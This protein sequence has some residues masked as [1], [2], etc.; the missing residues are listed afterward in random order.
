MNALR[1]WLFAPGNHD[2]KIEKVFKVAADVVVL[3]LEDSVPRASKISC[4]SKV[5]KALTNELNSPC[6]KYIRVNSMDTEFCYADI[7]EAIGPW[8]DGLLLPK[9]EHEHQLYTIDWLISQIERDRDMRVGGLDVVPIIET[10]IGLSN[11][12][13]IASTKTR[14][15]RLSFGAGDFTNDM[16][17][18]WTAEENEL[19]YA[20]SKISLAS[21]TARLEG[22]ID[23][24]FIDLSD[25][26][27]LKNSALTARSLGFTGKFCIHPAQIE[28]VNTAFT[29]SAEEIAL[30]QKQVTAFKEAESQGSSSIQVDGHF[31][32]YPIAERAQRTLTLIAAIEAKKNS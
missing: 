15:K 28:P 18:H 4:R 21:R 10:G 3:D 32:D 26:R 27:N 14:V 30:A 11:V 22:P 8:L 31:I 19:H 2:R 13:S 9:V 29:P 6:R 24:V 5:V 20:R 7:Q 17:M 16:G 1:T 23:T 25:E 12:D